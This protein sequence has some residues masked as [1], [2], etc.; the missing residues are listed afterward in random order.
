M[1]M[2]CYVMVMVCARIKLPVIR[3]EEV[4]HTVLTP[5]AHNGMCC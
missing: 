4:Q 3:G 2:V 1:V 5:A